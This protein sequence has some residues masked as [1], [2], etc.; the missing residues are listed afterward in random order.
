MLTAAPSSTCTLGVETPLFEGMLVVGENVEEGIAAEKV[1]DDADVVAAQEGVNAAIKDDVQEQ[2]IPSP[3]PP[4][5]LPQDLPSTSSVQ[6]TPPPSPQPQP[7]AA[8]FPLG[9]LQ[10]ALDTYATLTR[11]IE[12]LESAKIS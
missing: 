2:Y 9:L 11:R 7:Q 10:T 1:Q 12:Q 5:Q 6:S 3:T 4:P 8:D